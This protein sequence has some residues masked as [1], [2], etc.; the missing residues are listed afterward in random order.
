MNELERENKEL[1]KTGRLREHRGIVR[2]NK[3]SHKPR[4]PKIASKW[5]VKG[6]TFNKGEYFFK[7]F[8]NKID[9]DR[10]K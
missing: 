9:N 7:S 5:S 1:L 6:E 3:V 10:R 8:W 2:G 4:I